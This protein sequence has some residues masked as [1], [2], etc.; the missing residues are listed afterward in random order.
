VRGILGCNLWRSIQ[1]L[2][3]SVQNLVCFGILCSTVVKKNVSKKLR[4]VVVQKIKA[5]L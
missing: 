2:E 3:V 1:G 5:A 4:F